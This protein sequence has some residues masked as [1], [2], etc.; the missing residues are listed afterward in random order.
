MS[1]VMVILTL[2][3]LGTTLVCLRAPHRV[4]AIL[5][6]LT[7]VAAFVLA[8]TLVPIGV[9]HTVTALRYLRADSLSVIFVLGTCFLYATVGIYSVGYLADEHRAVRSATAEQQ[10]L[11]A[12]HSARFYVGLN[13][14]AWSMIC[15]PLVNGL[16]LLWIAVEITTVVSAL[17]VALDNTEGATEAAWKYVLIASSGLGIALLATIIMYYAGAQV[18][19]QSYD[20]AFDP[21]ISAARHCPQTPVRLAFVLAV[22]GYGTKVGLFPVHTWLPDAHAEAPTPVS[23]L[24]SGSLL[25]VSFYAILRYYQI[26]VGALGPRFPQIVLLV[27]GV[28]SLL[29]AALYLLEQ[30]DI[31]RL[32]AYSSVEHM[33][34]LAIGV[35]FGAPI[36]LSGVLLHVLAH[37]AAKGNA[38]MGAG[39]LVRKFATK[40]LARMANGMGIL[41]WSGPLFLTAVLALS[42]MPPFGLF[43][44]EFQIVA[45]GFAHPR[46]AATA[47]LV[48]LVTLAFLGL[49]L[50]TTRILFRPNPIESTAADAVLTRGEPSGWMVA[51]VVAGVVVLLVLGLAPPS[52]LVELLNHGASELMAGAQ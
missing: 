1:T 15:A 29:L 25:A 7:G 18:L 30:R 11:F 40:E 41:P 5:T 38:F 42:A 51:P 44:S 52:G 16:A 46:N 39:V 14:F 13:A 12:R 45:G 50:A 34:I 23:A 35:S 6:A 22:V 19:G 37:A 31:K 8:M 28:L 4:A 48:C 10:A 26:A 27:F 32:L 9:G 24:L 3:P 20:L 36:A 49:S 33:G 47:V 17:L 21:L 2:L 43:R